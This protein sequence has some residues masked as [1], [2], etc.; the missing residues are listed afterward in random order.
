VEFQAVLRKR[1]MVRAF[2]EREV[3]EEKLRVILE[4]AHRAPSAGHLQPQEFIVVR[5]REVKERLAEAALGQRFIA[6]AQVVIVVC[7]DMRRIVWRYGERGR[8]FYSII[9]GAFASM[10]ILLTA[11][12]LGLGACFVGAFRDED[13]SAILGLPRE[14][15][16]I[17]IIGI[18]YPAEPPERFRW[19]PL[20]E[21]VH[22]ERWGR[23]SP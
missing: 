4:N 7:S 22:Y 16:P 6:Q 5:S 11:V 15:R 8:H 18:G 2:Q 10:I 12:N 19:R 14:V 21:R 13:V 3:E 20:A 9:D 23:H 17:G 1:R